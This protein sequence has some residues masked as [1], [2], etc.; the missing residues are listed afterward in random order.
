MMLFNIAKKGWIFLSSM[1]IVSPLGFVLS[2]DSKSQIK[3][4]SS[5]ISF[6]KFVGFSN[7]IKNYKY[8]KQSIVRARI[9]YWKDGDTFDYEAYDETT[10]RWVRNQ[11]GRKLTLRI[12]FIDTPEYHDPQA[13]DPKRQG[14]IGAE[15]LKWAKAATEWAKIQI[16]INTEIRI[17]KQ[18]TDSYSRIVGSVFYN[19]KR[20]ANDFKDNFAVNIIRAG[21][22]LPR[23]ASKS[24]ILLAKGDEAEILNYLAIP[25]YLAWKEAESKKVNIY[26]LEPSKLAKVYKK[27]G[28]PTNYLEIVKK[29]LSDWL[30]E[31]TFLKYKIYKS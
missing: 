1:G 19:K 18:G 6:D 9:V 20:L 17:W 24:N 22:T 28:I 7:L 11:N 14:N 8:K 29:V 5:D 27:H 13:R 26:E 16:P 31:P 3:I 21:Y 4:E 12:S 30:M 2:C 25:L 23:I 15:E 10:S